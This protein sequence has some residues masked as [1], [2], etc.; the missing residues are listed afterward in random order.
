MAASEP[1]AIALEVLLVLFLVAVGANSRT[2]LFLLLLG[3]L[4]LW[5]RRIRWRD[6]GMD[7]PSHWGRTI[8][9]GVGISVV[10]QL[11]SISILVTVLQRLTGAELDLSQFEALRGNWTI[12]LVALITS[13]TLAA[14]GEEMA[15]RGYVLNRLAD[16]FGGSR[17]GWAI[18]V[19]VSSAIFGFGHLY[20]GATGIIE[21]FIS[22]IFLA[23]LY[24]AT[25]R[26]LWLPIIVHGMIDTIGFLLIFLGL[27]P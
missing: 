20:Q 2:I 17:L 16:L 22:G 27:Y 9:A 18:G 25:K 5:L 6:I 11:F 4:S 14:F 12:L 24:L 15:Y 10:Y 1:W 8:L 13:W 21:T 26:N 23:C 7:R 3:W 19:L